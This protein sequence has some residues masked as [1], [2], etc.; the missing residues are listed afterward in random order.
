MK[1]SALTALLIGASSLALATRAQAQEVVFADNTDL[2]AAALRGERVT[3][4]SG[5]TQIR[6]SSGAMLSF[7]E[8]AE[9]QLR[10]DGTVDLF[11]GNVTVT[12]AGTSEMVVRLGG[13]GSGKIS[14]ARVLWQLL[15]CH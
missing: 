13:E 7:V 11:K 15:G 1:T 8:G 3:Q 10:P 9:F 2:A 12:G 14:G 4:G 6:L 5:V